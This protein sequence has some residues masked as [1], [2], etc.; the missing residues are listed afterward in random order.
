[1]PEDPHHTETTAE[2]EITDASLLATSTKHY[3]SLRLSS[4]RRIVR[5]RSTTQELSGTN[6]FV[7]MRGEFVINRAS[8]DVGDCPLPVTDTFCFDIELAIPK[9]LAATALNWEWLK[10][11]SARRNVA[12]FIPLLEE[13]SYV[14]T[15]PISGLVRHAMGGRN[16][17]LMKRFNEL[18][19]PAKQKA[20]SST[21]ENLCSWSPQYQNADWAKTG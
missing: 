14:D 19:L 8:R 20:N 2:V 18:T 4:K 10:M 12:R 13:D 7:V 6:Q 17:V 5:T 11:R 1:M 21:P 3:C 16:S 9:H 15:F